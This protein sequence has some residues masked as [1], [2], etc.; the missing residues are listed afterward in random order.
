MVKSDDSKN[1]SSKKEFKDVDLSQELTQIKRRPSHPNSNSKIDTEFVNK[2]QTKSENIQMIKKPG[3]FV[4]LSNQGATCYLNSLLQTLFMTPEFKK[5]ILKWKYDAA[6]H[7]PKVDC[8]PYQLQKLFSR[9]Q[10]KIRS[11][12]ETKDLTKS[13]QWNSSEA[14]EQH[15]IQEL[16]R[17]LFDAIEISLGPDD[18]NFINELYEGNTISIVKC[19]ECNYMSQRFDKFLDLSL[20]IR[21]EFDKIYN[22]SLTMAIYNFLKPEILSKDNKYACEKCCKKVD[23]TKFYKFSKLPK[24]LFV[25]MMRFEYDIMTFQRKKI[26][27]KVTFPLLLNFNRYLKD[28]NEIIYDSSNEE[29]ENTCLFLKKEEISEENL[30]NFLNIDGNFEKGKSNNQNHTI[31]RF[32]FDQSL[33]EQ[34]IKEYLEE[35]PVVYE[36]FSIVIHSGSAL[37]GHYYAC[38]KSPDDQNWY[39]FNDSSVTKIDINDIKKI[40]GGSFG[41]LEGSSGFSTATGYVLLYRK[42]NQTSDTESISFSHDECISLINQELKKEIEEENVKILEEEQKW[43]ERFLN[44]TLKVVLNNEI[45]NIVIKK[46]DSVNDLKRRILIEYGMEEK[47]DLKD[48]KLRGY[49]QT[50]LKPAEYYDQEDS[51]LEENYIISYKL[52][53]LEFRNLSSGKF[54]IYDPNEITLFIYPWLDENEDKA[55]SELPFDVLK[56]SNKEII[57]ELRR[58]IYE[59]YDYNRFDQNLVIYRKHEFSTTNFSVSEILK[60]DEDLFKEIFRYPILDN[61]KLFVELKK[62]KNDPSKFYSLL[63]DKLSTITIRFNLP[64][65]QTLIPKSKISVK[66]YKLDNEIEIK[67]GWTVKKVKEMIAEF[68]RLDIDKFVIRKHNHNGD[69]ICNLKETVNDLVKGIMTSMCIYVELGKP[70]DED[71]QILNIYLCREDYSVFKFFPYKMTEIGSLLVKKSWKMKELKYNL[72]EEIKRKLGF[73]I[74]ADKVL[75]RDCVTDRPAKIYQDEEI[76]G[77]FNFTENKKILIHEYKRPVIFVN[78]M[79]MNKH[80]Q[81]CVRFWDRSNWIFR[82]PYEILITKKSKLDELMNILKIIYPNINVK[83]P[84]IL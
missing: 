20:P 11:A 71:E 23:A 75:L 32:V 15:D 51:S 81:V 18:K 41:G 7:G 63:T 46:T 44:L 78:N 5:N 13:F 83:Y 58:K 67:K 35:G 16:C 26:N 37:G 30:E 17:V 31:T 47:Y 29:N 69:E 24:I 22:K 38:I 43:Y 64:V 84:L 80:V 62:E 27:D 12:E 6:L 2:I 48:V 36:L 49:N 76:L 56:I 8:I 59:V 42:I 34:K 25:S 1:D 9:L 74:S 50:T 28:H 79:S 53:T 68:L 70:M 54:P 10:L 39:C 66:N 19:E 73:E 82:E 45:R 55:E 65:D 3:K 72:I 21:N 4:G 33:Y 14:W 77:T 52:Y 40:F 60:K 57:G 61:T